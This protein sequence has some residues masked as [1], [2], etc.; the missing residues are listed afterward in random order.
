MASLAAVYDK[1]SNG[2]AEALRGRLGGILLEPARLVARAR[3]HEDLLGGELAQRV[4][5]R[6]NRIRVSHLGTDFV[7]LGLDGPLG[8]S[9][10]LRGVLPRL[11]LV[12]R[13]P[14]ERRKVGCRRDDAYFCVL[15]AGVLTHAV[16]K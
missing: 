13:E 5:D 7:G 10:D 4:L 9:R 6:L 15:R 2:N 3:D 14:L 11:V 16:S 8:R 12:G 1:V